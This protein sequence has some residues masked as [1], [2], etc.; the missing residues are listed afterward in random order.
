M[1]FPKG[2]IW[3][4]WD[5]HIH[6]PASFHWNGGKQFADMDT[7][8]KKVSLNEIVR[9]INDSDV[10]AFA[11]V[12][13]WTFDGF[14]ALRAHIKL[15][16]ATLTK[17][18]FPGM[19]LRVE[20]PVDYR[21]NVQVL[22]SD[23]LTRQQRADFKAALRIRGIDR[24]VSDEALIEFAKQLSPDK[25]KTHGF[26]GN[27]SKDDV[28]LLRLGSQTAE[29]TRES[30]V[31]AKET[32]PDGACL[33]VLP[34]DT[35]DGL[36]KLD[37]AQHPCADQYFMQS[38][39]MF[40]TRNPANVD[41]FLGTTTESNKH[42]IGNFLATMGGRP[43]PPISG[44]DAHKTTDYGRFHGNRITWIKAD[45]TF[46]GLR[47]T[48]IE[49]EGRV[50]IG[51]C[52]EQLQIIDER[53]TKFIKSVTIKKKSDSTLTEHWF[54]C[55]IPINP[56]LVAI[57]GNKGNGKSA[58]GETIGL[59]GRTANTSAFSFLSINR[60]RQRK[61]NKAAHFEASLVW[62]SGNAECATLE[63]DPDPGAYELIKYIP[64][65]YLETLCNE[66][67]AV[68][69]A[70]FDQELRSV[71]FS[72]VRAEDRL[73]QSTLEDLIE[74]QTAQATAKIELLQKE[75][76]R[77]T[78]KTVSL[79]VR[80]TPEHRMKLEGALAA[81]Q[82]ELEGHEKNR[83]IEV[84]RPEASEEKKEKLEKLSMQ[85]ADKRAE[86]SKEEL[87]ITATREGLSHVN[88]LL[89]AAH[90]IL[91]G[92]DNFER[93][94]ET[95]KTEI[96]ADIESLSLKESE[97]VTL[98]LSKEAVIRRRSALL[99]DQANLER[100]LNRDEQGSKVSTKENIAAEL[101]K[102]QS[103]LD[104]P[105]KAYEAYLERKD[106]WNKMKIRL[107]GGK[108]TAD[109]I[110]F[111]KDQIR[112]LTVL[113]DKIEA[114]R[115][116][117]V[118]K[119]KEIFREKMILAKIYRELYA[120]VQGFIDSSSVAK[121]E[122]KLRFDVQI[123]DAGFGDTFFSY[124]SQGVRGTYCGA[125]EGW[126]RLKIL[127]SESDFSTESG[128]GTFVEKLVASLLT[129]ER[130]GKR[131]TNVSDMLK[132]GQTAQSV[133]NAIYGLD[134][135][136]PRYSLGMSG[137]SLHELSPGE[138]GALLLVFYLLVDQNDAPLIMDQPE[139]NL[140]NQTV[141]NLLVPCIKEAKKRRQ[142]V[143]I[144]HNPNLAV[145]CDAEQIICCSIDKQDGNRLTYESGAIENPEI[146]RTI[147][148]ILEGTRPAFDN[149]SSKYLE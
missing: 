143:V 5:L 14:E 88:M 64:Q 91:A 32:I 128:V 33:I 99:D 89:S 145:V 105:H 22:L 52:P 18:V 81:K 119:T 24:A 117:A 4:K 132:K 135:L 54:D 57:I 108:D 25:A 78:S 120:P 116:K 34:Y 125:G 39:D 79:E 123:L 87:A 38:A 16:E 10:V 138:R 146:N 122:L 62:L 110:G 139:E 118:E 73:G 106:I 1:N 129:D 109:S 134:Y 40:E 92:I 71:I 142:I 69:E 27:Y 56:G 74:Y 68:E 140:D 59:L 107:I 31:A 72:H 76:K 80:G 82:R 44:S 65:N 61:N 53:P 26:T 113:P 58:L 130:D 133:Y 9:A 63:G 37:W 46:E 41:L 124:V 104:A 121:D 30:L 67:G 45:P 12:D 127:L 147:V 3:K 84:P 7:V 15:G 115:Q 111:Y 100:E 131:A 98:K 144:T 97:I 47:K 95:F 29:V 101:K 6:T 126:K 70:G 49:P 149:R 43:K 36:E 77:I 28:K 2:S 13:Y 35:S 103:Q 75:L 112:E 136:R 93:Q 60:F 83:P 23:T 85:L 66:L 102:I 21:L 42:F 141:F 148:D 19:E 86:L 55:E 90:R 20:A 50:F 114:E 94:V 51:E 8:E 137:K 48:L 11:V 17:T 96:A